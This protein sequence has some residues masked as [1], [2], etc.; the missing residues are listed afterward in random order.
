M[1]GHELYAGERYRHYKGGLYQIVTVAVHTET[2]EDMVV[3]QALYGDYKVFV[4]PL[5]MFLET[6]KDEAG[7]VVPR[8]AKEDKSIE[9]ISS[10]RDISAKKE[11]TENSVVQGVN[12]LLITFLD[13]ESSV[14][15]LEILHRMRKSI[16]NKTI[17]DMAAALDIVIEEKDMDERIKDLENCLQ[18]RARFETTRL[19]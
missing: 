3:Y 16:D 9:K 6:V 5:K 19:R 15:K 18:T 8:F 7:N 2:E 1:N 17:S 14:E 11:E 12:P 10:I 4:R 13:A